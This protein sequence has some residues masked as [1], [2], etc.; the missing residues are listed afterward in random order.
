MGRQEGPR[1]GVECPQGLGQAWPSPVVQWPFLRPLTESEGPP[2]PCGGELTF[3]RMFLCKTG[4]GVTVSV[5]LRQPSPNLQI[6]IPD[7]QNTQEPDSP[8]PS[9]SPKPAPEDS[10]PSSPSLPRGLCSDS[11]LCSPSSSHLAS[12]HLTS[13]A[14]LQGGAVSEGPRSCPH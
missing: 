3:H 12:S 10:P 2:V 8:R 6:P 7:A 9:P 1:G 13:K 11:S 14:Q 4:L 5:D